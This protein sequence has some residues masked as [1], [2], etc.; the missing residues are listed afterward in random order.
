MNASILKYIDIHMIASIIS[1]VGLIFL[2]LGVFFFSYA[3]GIEQEI[4]GININIVTSDILNIIVPTLTPQQKANFITSLTY[5]DMAKED[6]HVATSNNELVASA[7]KILGIISVACIVFSFIICYFNGIKFFNILGLNLIVLC[8]VGL[9]EF[10][11]LHLLPK[12]FIAADT[13]FV[14]FVALTNL[15]EKLNLS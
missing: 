13:N 2:F 8:F 7:L 9:T 4:V 5:P 10:S 12:K 15:K 1:S 3:A 14:R 11:F 6:A